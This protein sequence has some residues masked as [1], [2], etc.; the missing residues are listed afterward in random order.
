MACGALEKSGADYAVSVTGLA[1]PG[2]DGS[3]SPVGTVWIAVS[4]RT[5]TAVLLQAVS[6]RLEGSRNAIRREA[7]GKALGELLKYIEPVLKHP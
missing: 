3:A 1:G 5:E 4:R 2:G 6:F 7:A